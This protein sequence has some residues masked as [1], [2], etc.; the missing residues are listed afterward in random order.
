MYFTED[1]AK[2]AGVHARDSLG[3]YLTV[4][5]SPIL[6]GETSALAF[7]PDAR[8]LYVTYQTMGRLYAIWRRDG[9]PF[10]GTQLDLKYHEQNNS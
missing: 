8:I 9:L 2:K 4:L 5:E 1:N 7:S 10:Y 3:H 6:L